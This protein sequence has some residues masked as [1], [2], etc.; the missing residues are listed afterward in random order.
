MT[1]NATTESAAAVLA[2]AEAAG[3]RVA[4][5][6]SLTG[7]AL[8]SALV[9][10]PGASKVFL[11]SVVAY[12]S[13]A[14]HGILGVSR[15]LLTMQGAVDPEV[16]A[17]MALGAAAKFANA[18]GGSEADSD[19]VL[20]VSTTGVAGPDPQDGKPVGQVYIGI[21]LGGRVEV[22]ELSLTG[23]RAS[24]RGQVV[25]AALER[26]LAFLASK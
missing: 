5:A 21:A 23:D 13:S 12:D 15:S 9:E 3:I 6:E 18:L 14:K 19:A 11:G 10:V 22:H 7:G 16:A 17:Q 26:T 20:G 24:I 2:A 1:S 4:L 25:A 8:S